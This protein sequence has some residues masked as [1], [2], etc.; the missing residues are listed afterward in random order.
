MFE[1][2]SRL[3]KQIND[4]TKHLNT[5][6]VLLAEIVSKEEFYRYCE[7]EINAVTEKRT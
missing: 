6:S 5:V 7:E 2:E 1:E 3:K 4:I